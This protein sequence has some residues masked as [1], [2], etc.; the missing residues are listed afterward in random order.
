MSTRL[1]HPS[2]SGEPSA[3]YPESVLPDFRILEALQAAVIITDVAGMIT[4]W[5]PF[6]E[7][8]YG[9]SSKEVLGKSIIRITVSTESAEEAAQHMSSLRSGNSWA[10]EFGVR[11]KNGEVLP[12]LVTL[13]P[14]VDESGAVIAIVGVSQDLRGRKQ[15]E[16]E[17]K[18]A[19]AELETQVTKRTEELNKANHSLRDLSAQLMLMRD[20]EARRLARE[21]HDSVGQLLVAISLNIAIVE[22]QC[23][24][25]DEHGTKALTETK[26]FV[27]EINREIRTM[28]HLLHP[29]LLDEA[30][31]ASALNWYIEGFSARSNI[32]VEIDIP[33]DFGRLSAEKETAIFRMVQECLT[34]IHRHSE[35]KTASIRIRNQA[36]QIV[37]MVQDSGKG[38]PPAKLEMIRKGRSGIGFRGIAERVSYM[39]GDFKI[40]SSSAGTT[41]AA[42]VPQDAVVKP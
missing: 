16:N 10:G 30:G 41:V 36:A 19:H 17:L 25:L 6:A 14:L 5:N 42:I 40:E 7:K 31:I 1:S 18:K 39:G 38:I 29:P 23:S 3:S 9:W 21:L 4:F 34:N 28:S 32:K 27:E 8:L 24:K 26:N 12:A 13:T 11:C 2:L 22:S 33:S 15:V 20:L 37:I 35:S